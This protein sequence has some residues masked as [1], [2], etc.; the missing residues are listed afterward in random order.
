[1]KKKIIIVATI[2]V[3]VVTAA[4]LLFMKKSNDGFVLEPSNIFVDQNDESLYYISGA[5]ADIRFIIKN[6][7]LGAVEIL[8][9]QG[10]QVNVKEKIAD[11]AVIVSSPEQ[12]YMPGEE[13]SITLP[14]GASFASDALKNAEK[15]IFSIG[16]EKVEEYAFSDS[17]VQ[18][19]DV[20]EFDSNGDV[21]VKD[22]YAIGDIIFG[23][24]KDGEYHA[25]KIAELKGGSASYTIPALDEVYSELNVYGQYGWDIDYISNNPD[26]A[27]QIAEDFKNTEL[28]NG[29][30]LA[31][32]AVEFENGI[33]DG[34]KV[35]IE[36]DE[37]DNS[38]TITIKLSFKPNSNNKYFS[39][40]QMKNSRITVTLSEKIGFTTKCDIK[41]TDDW[42]VKAI[43]HSKSSVQI[44]FVY[45]NEV[46]DFEKGFAKK[47]TD[48]AGIANQIN[49]VIEKLET[50]IVDNVNGEVSL[51]EVKINVPNV[52]GLYFS[53]EVKLFAKVNIIA[54]ATL[55]TGAE[56]YYTQGLRFKD[57]KF[58]TYHNFEKNEEGLDLTVVGQV[59]AKAGIRIEFKAVFICDEMCSII[60]APEGGFYFDGYLAANANFSSRNTKPFSASG[61]AEIG[62]YIAVNLKATLN[63]VVANFSYPTIGE[64]ELFELK[65][66]LK[67]FG[68]KTIPIAIFPISEKIPVVDNVICVPEIVYECFDITKKYTY[69][70]TLDKDMLL[71]TR[72]GNK[73]LHIDN[74]KITVPPVEFSKDFT[75]YVDYQADNNHTLRCEFVVEVPT[76]TI[77]GTIYMETVDEEIVIAENATITIYSEYKVGDKPVAEPVATISPDS[78]GKYT[79]KVIEGKYLLVVDLEGYHQESYNL[80]INKDEAVTVDFTLLPTMDTKNRIAAKSMEEAMQAYFETV[81]C[82]H[83]D[84]LNAVKAG[85]LE[86]AAV[87]SDEVRKSMVKTCPIE[88]WETSFYAYDDSDYRRMFESYITLFWDYM[89][90]YYVYNAGPDYSIRY[91]IVTGEKMQSSDIKAY[92][93]KLTSITALQGVDLNSDYVKEQNKYYDF[94]PVIETS[95]DDAYRLT[96]KYTVEGSK[97]NWEAVGEYTAI[98]TDG[99]WYILKDDHYSIEYGRWDNTITQHMSNAWIP[100][101]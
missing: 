7:T 86:Y 45:K 84:R 51:T 36:P 95:L 9:S 21:L 56:Y 3:L 30:I 42:D 69:Q 44:D 1:M 14:A 39:L 77:E 89:R 48:V 81:I 12:G 67:E 41:G 6:A 28:Y 24:S 70:E 46:I 80:T 101:Y 68:D 57:N 66:P 64:K 20:I 79:F 43:V 58:S 94:V 31:A 10:T 26:I 72:S 2:L 38:I 5:D 74:G 60:I 100:R 25:L 83:Q 65:V 52:P 87:V 33:G 53:T 50:A 18:E 47:D 76:S 73:E 17:V 32:S 61:Y 90:G 11:N 15:V 78:E 88:I 4:S 8:D 92:E 16:R 37:D 93:K 23:Q 63:L 91:E 13:Y 55:K 82:G 29:L 99:K 34:L 85:T 35:E 19:A 40:E 62:V 27:M 97:Q 59:E 54:K 22:D 71:Y 96:V 98:N 75:V 49:S